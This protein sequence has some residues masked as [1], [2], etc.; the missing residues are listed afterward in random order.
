MLLVEHSVTAE[1]GGI[2]IGFSRLSW[3]TPTA[4]PIVGIGAG[5]GVWIACTVLFAI[6]CRMRRFAVQLQTDHL[7][8]LKRHGVRSIR[9]DRISFID[10]GARVD[11]FQGGEWANTR[12]RIRVADGRT[13]RIGLNRSAASSLVGELR[14]RCSRAGGIG[15]DETDWLPNDPVPR[16]E[17]RRR[18]RRTLLVRAIVGLVL[19]GTWLAML[20]VLAVL[21]VVSGHR[22][23]SIR[24]WS[25]L[26][27]ASM[28][29]PFALRTFR[30]GAR[31]SA[32][33][34]AA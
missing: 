13:T 12:V 4:T 28:A 19:G 21:V 27:F 23:N 8:I 2:R 34:K 18:L 6:F 16:S 30:R 20:L 10:A 24:D 31:A 33:R 1:L 32:R 14:Y 9:Y 7:D 17:A 22:H 5:I 25:Q 29:I 26:A 11:T 15:S 3:A